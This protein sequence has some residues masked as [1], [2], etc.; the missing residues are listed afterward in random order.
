MGIAVR[1]RNLEIVKVLLESGVNPNAEQLTMHVDL[2]KSPFDAELL[3][4]QL[5]SGKLSFSGE[6][7]PGML[8]IEK[9]TALIF[10]VKNEM[11]NIVQLILNYPTD[12]SLTDENG[13]TALDHAKLLGYKDIEMLLTKYE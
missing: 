12:A 7:P 10:A 3:Q 8:R 2:S 9:I 13:M 6:V 4:E 5:W 1:Q 11:T